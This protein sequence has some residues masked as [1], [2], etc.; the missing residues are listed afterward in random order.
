MLL[1]KQ[2]FKIVLI[3]TYELGRQPFGLASP[4]AWLRNEGFNVSTIDIAVEPFSQQEIA[5][6]DVVA[7][8]VPMHTATRL[9]IELVH[10]IKKINPDAHLCFY[11]LYAPVNESYLREL[12]AHTI[13]GGEFE[14]GIVSLCKRLCTNERAKDTANQTEETISLPHLQFQKPDRKNLPDLSSYAKLFQYEQKPKITGYVEAS[15]GCKHHCRHC[16]IVPVYNGKFRIIQ[17]EIVLQDIRQQVEAGAQH[18]TFGDPD[19]LNG[20]GHA[21]PIVQSLHQEFPDITY[22]VT[23]KIE[24]LLKHQNLLPILKET[25]CAIV[26]SAVESID[27][28]ILE[29]FDKGHTRKDFIKVAHIL[30]E[31]ELNLNPTFVTFT[32]WTTLQGYQELL[33][34]LNELN[35]IGNISPIQLA[36]RLL[37]PKES[38]LLELPETQ[39]F[40]S[41]F[42]QEMLTYEWKN[43]DQ[44]VEELFIKVRNI[45]HFG[46]KQ[47]LTRHELFKKIWNCTNELLNQ[48]IPLPEN[49]HLRKRSSIPYLNEPWYC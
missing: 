1:Q 6:A 9:A 32:P 16:P 44:L 14:E 36:I 17:K 11:G 40:I 45:I 42:N 43:P 23:I 46:Q 28:H 47:D 8:Y 29:I 19:F 10:K 31:I 20:P 22:D 15:R 39:R 18:I 38:K 7:F 34:L 25:S 12:G 21:I 13:L 5:L 33:S 35:L 3:S 48:N 27:N 37:I 24:H 41:N 4:A 2:S 49:W 30:D 26:T